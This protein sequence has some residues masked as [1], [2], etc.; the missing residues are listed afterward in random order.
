VAGPAGTS[1]AGAV[2][3]GVSLD[4]SAVGGGGA[5]GARASGGGGGRRTTGSGLG[6]S[7]GSAMLTTCIVRPQRHHARMR[8][9]PFQRHAMQRPDDRDKDNGSAARWR[10]KEAGIM[11][12]SNAFTRISC[13]LPVLNS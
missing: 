6:A 10:E 12:A 9:Q 4:G 7:A 5:A 11:S 8:S 3:T 1:L 13:F 2:S